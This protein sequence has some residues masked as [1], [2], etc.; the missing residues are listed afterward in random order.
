MDD[1]GT[2]EGQPL[3]RIRYYA[4]IVPVWI[5][6][7]KAVPLPL[8]TIGSVCHN[9][10]AGRALPVKIEV[11][12]NADIAVRM[13]AFI[14]RGNGGKMSHKNKKGKQRTYDTR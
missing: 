14:S 6:D 4:G 2:G 1:T 12:M 11:N 9:L 3:P 10:G 5:I 7:R 8:V 13:P